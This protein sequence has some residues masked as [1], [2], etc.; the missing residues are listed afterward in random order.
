M[1]D[2]TEL[3][4][5]IKNIIES[6]EK[7]SI[8]PNWSEY[9]VLLASVVATRSPSAKLKV[10][11]I[12]VSSDNEIISTGYNGFPSGVPHIPIFNKEGKEINT[13]HAEINTI[14]Y[15]ARKGISIKNSII[16]ITHF[17]CIHC[18]KSI[19]AAGIKNI[20]Y[21]SDRNND[22]VAIEMM[23]QSNIGIVK[24]NI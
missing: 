10:G 7:I 24:I 17:P 22:P 13:I 23:K 20:F 3:K 2:I 16:Y 18:T 8:R 5:D 9:F 19:I 15:A 12:I 1:T 6:I 14:S 21:I 11:A 4:T